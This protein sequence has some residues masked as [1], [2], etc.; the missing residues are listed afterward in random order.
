M[1]FDTPAMTTILLQSLRLVLVGCFA[2]YTIFAFVAT[3]Q[4]DV[5]SRTLDTPLS[6]LLRSISYIHLL[7]SFLTIIFVFFYLA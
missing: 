6:P 4:V 2:I 5:M 1:P 3:R 7:F